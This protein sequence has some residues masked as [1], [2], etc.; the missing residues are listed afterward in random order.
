M[1]YKKRKKKRVSINKS[2]NNKR[3]TTLMV[4]KSHEA[5]KIRGSKTT[6]WGKALPPSLMIWIKSLRLIR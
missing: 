5:L 4:L 3:V 1:G 2:I 6:Q